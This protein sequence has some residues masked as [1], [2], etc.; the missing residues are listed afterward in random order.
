MLLILIQII[1]GQYTLSKKTSDGN[2]FIHFYPS[3]LVIG[4]IALGFE[5]FMKNKF[6]QELSFNYKQFP[7][8]S[9]ISTKASELTILQSTVSTPV[10]AFA[11][12]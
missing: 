9:I 6:G 11:F 10:S 12:L 3:A 2:L 5:H 4:D 7:T 8:N 1:Q